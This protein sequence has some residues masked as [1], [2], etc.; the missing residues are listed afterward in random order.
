MIVSSSPPAAGRSSPPR[1]LC[2]YGVVL[3]AVPVVVVAVRAKAWRALAATLLT[4]VAGLAILGLWGFSW[5]AG[6]LQTRVEYAH[7]LSHTR[8]YAYWL[9][10]NAATF[11]VL[12]GPATAAALTRVRGGA[13]VLVLAG[14]AC[15]VIAGLSGMSSAE[16]ERIWQPFAPLVLLAGAALWLTRDGFDVARARRWLA[17]QV[18]VAVAF[19]G[20]LHSPW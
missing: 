3:L 4:T 11:A 17:L 19:Q 10:G 15:P 20:A 6:L 18:A 7:S 12:I 5:P 9:L 8:G 14:L 2:T 1:S 16:T 13:R